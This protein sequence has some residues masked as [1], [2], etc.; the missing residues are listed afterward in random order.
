MS[1]WKSSSTP[2]LLIPHNPLA[3]VDLK[4]FRK[5]CI[6]KNNT[7]DNYTLEERRKILDYLAERQDIYA[8]AI[9]LDF[10]LCV[11]IVELLAIKYSDIQGGFLHINRSMRGTYEMDDDMNFSVGKITNEERIKGNQSTGFRQIP[12]TDKALAIVEKTHSL[13]PDNE[14]LLMRD[15]KQLIPNTF[16]EE[17]YM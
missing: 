17:L 6:P 3:N 15:N 12:L 2:L 4:P 14:Y 10:Y 1:I 8:L 7:K 16:N 11:R 9:Q 13:Y 5:R